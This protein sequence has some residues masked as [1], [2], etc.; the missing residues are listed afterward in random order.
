M[1]SEGIKLMIHQGR[2]EVLRMTMI[3]VGKRSVENRVRNDRIGQDLN[4]DYVEEA[5]GKSRLRLSG[6]VQ[7]MNDSRL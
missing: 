7:Y 6:H 2:F 5:A 4:V 1:E 3:S